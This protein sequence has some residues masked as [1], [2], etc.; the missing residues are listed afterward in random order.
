MLKEKADLMS[1]F[2]SNSLEEATPGFGNPQG[3]SSV[4]VSVLP[5]LLPQTNCGSQNSEEPVS[6]RPTGVCNGEKDVPNEV[7]CLS[8]R[9]V[10][11]FLTCG[12][13]H[14]TVIHVIIPV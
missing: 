13:W 2:S 5:R 6:D 4:L 9:E 12:A 11:L 7:C 14:V 3:D 8:F 1:A 10:Y